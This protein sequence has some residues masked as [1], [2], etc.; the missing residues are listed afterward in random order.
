M[1]EAEEL[2][3][4]RAEVQQMRAEMAGLLDLCLL[5]GSDWSA[6]PRMGGYR[7]KLL[8]YVHRHMVATDPTL[9]RGPVV[10]E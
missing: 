1:I 4:L 10:G 6:L 5:I 9:T 3:A 8:D 7:R 2:A